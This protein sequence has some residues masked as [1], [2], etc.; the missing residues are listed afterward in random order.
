M[1]PLCR[2]IETY[3]PKPT[4][5]IYRLPER[6][7]YAVP[8][9]KPRLRGLEPA[10]D[11]AQNRPFA[12]A[13]RIE[14]FSNGFRPIM[15]APLLPSS[16][17]RS[18][19]SMLMPAAAAA[20]AAAGQSAAGSRRTGLAAPL[21]RLAGRRRSV[22]GARPWRRSSRASRARSSATNARPPRARPTCARSWRDCRRGLQ[23]EAHRV[24][25]EG[26]AGQPR[27]AERVFAFPDPLLGS[28]AAVVEL[29]HLLV[30]SGSG[31]SR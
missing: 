21:P 9:R 31:W 1:R 3:S 14:P 2:L 11:A 6:R 7:R 18:S 8:T 4:F 30:G 13:A 24:V 23:L 12:L 22:H 26:M 16:C 5:P 10:T 17:C 19:P 29:D 15:D 25:A 28:A 27:P 20:L